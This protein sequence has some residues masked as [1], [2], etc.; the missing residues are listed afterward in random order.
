MYTYRATSKAA[1]PAA[2]SGALF[3]RFVNFHSALQ[4]AGSKLRDSNPLWNVMTAS[5]RLTEV[6][7]AG[8]SLVDRSVSR[9]CSV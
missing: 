1:G 3:Q 8:H 4:N 2:A 9:W 7:F 5:C 6:E